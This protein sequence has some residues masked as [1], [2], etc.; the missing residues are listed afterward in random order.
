LSFSGI[1]LQHAEVQYRITRRQTWWWHW[2]GSV[3]QFT[4]GALMTDENGMF[5]IRFT[6]EKGD[7]EQGIRSVYSFDVEATITDLNGETQV[8]NYS[9]T[10]GDVSMMLQ[11]EM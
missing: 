10:V 2:G 9:I 3:D 4:E 7:G 8:G 1:K 6:P 5:E 11:L